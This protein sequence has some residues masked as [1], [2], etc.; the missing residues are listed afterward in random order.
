MRVSSSS[1][2]RPARRSTAPVLRANPWVALA[3]TLMLWGS[4][5]PEAPVADA[6]RA[7]DVDE[8]RTLLRG[9]EDANA[10]HGDGMTALH[11]AAEH[12]NVE[13]AEVLLVAGAHPEVVTR[14]GG[15]T[16]LH[17]AAR[18][19]ASGVVQVLLEKGAEP[20]A[21]TDPAG[22]Q[23]LHYAAAAGDVVSVE[24]LVTRGAVVDSREPKWGQTPLM[25][26]AARGRTDVVRSLIAVGADPGATAR[27]MD[28][29]EREQLDRED[30]QRREEIREALLAAQEGRL[31]PTGDRDP[32]GGQPLGR[33]AP[34]PTPPAAATPPD[35][36]APPAAAVPPG[37]A[38][39]A[40][41]QAAPDAPTREDLN[42]Q[43]RDRVPSSRFSHAQLVGGY[44]G[45]APLHLAARDG[46]RATAMALVESGADIDQ[47]SG[48]DGSTPLLIAT[49]NGHFDLAMELFRAGADPKLASD[50]NA[51]PLYTTINTQ[52]IPKSRHPQPADY[53][54]Q[55]VTYLDLMKAFLD[56]GVDPDVRLEKQLWF[57]T[58]GDDYLRV[59]RMGATPFWRAAYAL[60]LEAM[61]LL[62]AYGADPNIPTMKT[63]PPRF[64]RS[65]PTGDGPD[66]SGLPPVPVGGPGVYPVHAASGVGYGE[67]FAANI[68]RVVPDGWLPA[69]KY[70]VEE[71]GADVNER[72]HNGYTAVHHAASRGD[73]ELILYLVEQGAEV[74]VVARSGQTTVDMANGPVQRISPFP[75]TIE[76]LESLGAKNNHNCVSC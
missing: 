4:L 41:E 12:G 11:W 57:T 22:V 52:W 59:D 70:L 39:P 17:I 69:M 21:R 32:Y 30:R 13:L 37:A 51:T 55:E 45:L 38:R 74:T 8:V 29:D 76:L 56:A 47:R 26:A 24:A 40:D 16:P 64:G 27:V 1:I 25:Y 61:R 54:Q 35:P 48:G 7:N 18:K 6:A 63:A 67:G 3:A 60:D 65:A 46:H 75:E 68:H 31:T 23:P 71:L 72:D 44:G 53:M 2:M 9:G 15:Y 19:G 5:A 20:A 36:G 28:M 49:I 73:N 42:N 10:A 50:A 43:Q 62:V 58:F 34:P 66:P 33:G 14:L